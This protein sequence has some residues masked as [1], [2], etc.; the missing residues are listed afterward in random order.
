MDALIKKEEGLGGLRKEGGGSGE[1]GGGSAWGREE[2]VKSLN[3]AQASELEA[4]NGRSG[5]R[6]P[7][8]GGRTSSL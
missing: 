5:V 1:G 3:G 6:A 2:V 7:S 8:A 4:I